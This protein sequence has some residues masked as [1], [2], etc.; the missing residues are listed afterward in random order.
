MKKII[1]VMVII[2][3]CSWCSYYEHNYTR[4]AIV[5]NVDCIEVT[6]KDSSEHYWTLMSNN[7]KVGDTITL[8]MYDN[9]TPNN[10][11]DDVIKGVK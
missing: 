4:Q 10:M 6:V 9:H 2:V 3:L 7:H 8:Q 1:I 11:Y 5:T